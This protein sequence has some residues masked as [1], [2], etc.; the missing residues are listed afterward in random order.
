M[1]TWYKEKMNF[2]HKEMETQRKGI[3][4]QIQS[5]KREAIKFYQQKEHDSLN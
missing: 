4:D 5:L 3:R 1:D 2:H